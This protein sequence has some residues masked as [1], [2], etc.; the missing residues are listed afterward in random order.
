MNKS[1]YL[2]IRKDNFYRYS[3]HVPSL[4]RL[5]SSTTDANDGWSDRRR[6]ISLWIW[7]FYKEKENQISFNFHAEDRYLT[8]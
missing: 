1:W 7:L 5:S 3:Q 2:F 6:Y 4:V 8:I